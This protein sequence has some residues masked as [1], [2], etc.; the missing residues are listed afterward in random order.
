MCDVNAP[1]FVLKNV[2]KEV[3]VYWGM[4]TQAGLA[5]ID[6]SPPHACLCLPA[7]YFNLLSNLIEKVQGGCGMGT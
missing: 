3:W 6:Y 2:A 4:A 7:G 1:K 5:L